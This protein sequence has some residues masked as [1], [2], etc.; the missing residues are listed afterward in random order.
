MTFRRHVTTL[1]QLTVIAY[2]L[3]AAGASTD[4]FAA[5]GSVI[6]TYDALGRV[7]TASYDTNVVVDYAY[8]S[9]GNRTAQTINVNTSGL[10]WHASTVVP[11]T[12]S[13]WDGA[14]WQ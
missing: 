1:I 2:V 14:L 9:N 3:T 5:N 12:S 7:L 6:Y 13:C 4:S 11:C 8:D 10:T